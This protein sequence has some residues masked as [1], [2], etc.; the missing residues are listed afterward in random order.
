M[1]VWIIFDG[2]DHGSFTKR[3]WNIHSLLTQALLDYATRE[4][5]R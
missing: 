4:R 3:G 2:G 1:M 5:R